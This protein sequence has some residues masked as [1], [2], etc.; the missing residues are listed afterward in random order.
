MKIKKNTKILLIIFE[1]IFIIL[2][3]IILFLYQKGF[4]TLIFYTP[5]ETDIYLNL[6]YTNYTKPGSNFLKFLNN[7][8]VLNIK[9]LEN[10][11][12]YYQKEI[13][14]FHDKNNNFGFILRKNRAGKNI[15]VETETLERFMNNYLSI[16]SKLYIK[17]IDSIVYI[18]NTPDLEIKKYGYFKNNYKEYLSIYLLKNQNFIKGLI[19]NSDFK[20]ILSNINFKDE[21]VK[22]TGFINNFQNLELNIENSTYNNKEK[23]EE[24]K[25]NILKNGKNYISLNEINLLD[26]Y[27]KLYNLSKN[28]EEFKWFMDLKANFEDKYKFNQ[29]KL[30]KLLN[31]NSDIYLNIQDKKINE[32]CIL[33]DLKNLNHYIN[34]IINVK[35]IF[36]QHAAIES[37]EIKEITL[38][39]GT[40]VKELIMNI[41]NVQFKELYKSTNKEIFGLE[42]END[43]GIYY[44][45]IDGRYFS[46]SNNLELIESIRKENSNNIL[47][48]K[49][50]DIYIETINYN[51]NIKIIFE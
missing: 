9:E 20:N 32:F 49:L 26:F 23:E 24:I 50:N 11:K 17:E 16:D 1:V 51:N 8:N 15:K 6:N 44:S 12:K 14:F 10:I 45:L 37:P 31:N 42:I 29:E 47:K 22:I 38:E 46:I 48:I 43:G 27:Q 41:K 5:K 13:S 30:N 34:E 39:D 40:K 2:L 4:D 35:D 18:S 25:Y 33:F 19:N 36:L 21:K 7:K 3:F 28:N